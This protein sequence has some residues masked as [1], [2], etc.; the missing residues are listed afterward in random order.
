[1][2][3][4]AQE[5]GAEKRRPAEKGRNSFIAKN[6]TRSTCSAISSGSLLPSPPISAPRRGTTA[7]RPVVPSVSR[8]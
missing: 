2:R 6:I 5:T 4:R 7:P 8:C 1:L 3:P